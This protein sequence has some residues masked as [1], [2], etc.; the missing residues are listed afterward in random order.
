MSATWLQSELKTSEDGGLVE[1][2]ESSFGLELLATV[3]WV[4]SQEGAATVED[5]VAKT[6]AWNDRKKRFSARQIG[7]AWN[8]LRNG[9]W[10]SEVGTSCRK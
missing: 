8:S 9:G 1:G 10:L 2:F 7:I 6:Y 3:H 4:A 5:V